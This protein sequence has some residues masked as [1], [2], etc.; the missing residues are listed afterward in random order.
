MA[1]TVRLQKGPILSKILLLSLHA[2]RTHI[3]AQWVTISVY[4]EYLT[5]IS[6][7][8]AYY[9]VFLFHWTNG[10]VGGDSGLKPSTILIPA[11]LPLHK[12]VLTL[13]VSRF[14][15]YI[16]SQI[17]HKITVELCLF[18]LQTAKVCG[19]LLVICLISARPTIASLTS[20]ES[21]ILIDLVFQS[22]GLNSDLLDP[23]FPFHS[24]LQTEAEYGTSFPITRWQSKRLKQHRADQI[25]LPT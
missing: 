7:R 17:K 13:A 19:R 12:D 6:L 18:S 14:T 20:N 21:H 8:C 9:V 24:S 2:N 3:L 23:S 5:V 10:P 15:R 1:R 16:Y 4:A 25:R 11:A 22:R